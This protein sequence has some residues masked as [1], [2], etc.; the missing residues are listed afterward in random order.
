LL[1]LQLVAAVGVEAADRAEDRLPVHAQRAARGDQLG[2]HPQLPS[3]AGVRE[4]AG[5][6]LTGQRAGQR[7]LILERL[8]DHVQP[9]LVEQPGAR[10][11]QH[12]GDRDRQRVAAPKRVCRS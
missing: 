4:G 1:D 6:R 9:R 2:R 8:L 5:R 11:L 12:F 10:L 3:Q 7:A